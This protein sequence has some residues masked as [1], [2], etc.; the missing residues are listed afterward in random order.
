[1]L[2]TLF[3]SAARGV[4]KRT[5]AAAKPALFSTA[6]IDPSKMDITKAQT[7]KLFPP[8]EELLFGQL[9]TDHM[10]EIDWTSDHGWHAP[11]IR[12]YGPFQMD[13]A[14]SVLHYGLECFEGMKG[15]LDSEGRTRLFRPDMNMARMKVSCER[16]NLPDFDGD[17]FLEC[18]K[19]LVRLDKGCIPEGDGFSLYLRP[20]AISTHPYLGVTGAQSSKLYCILSPVGPYYPEGFKPVTLY[21]DNQN[22]RAWPGGVGFTKCGGNY[23]PTIKVQMDAAKKGYS[24]VLWLFGDDDQLTEVGTMNMFTF[25]VNEDGDKELVTAPL[26]GTILPGVTRDTILNLAR[27]WGEFKVTERSYTMAEMTKAIEEKRLIECFGAGTAAVVSPIR[28]IS[29]HGTEY[30]VPLDPKNPDA[31]AGPLTQ[32]VWDTIVGIQYG[33]DEHEW[34]VVID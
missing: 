22:R 14:A 20:T 8:K 25:W 9:F 7:R 34:S 15:Y 30:E 32:R 6:S 27:G 21:A 12:P 5:G 17:A 24:Q 18:I 31:V 28:L 11:V 26:D 19:E 2:S 33:R 16:M 23:A 29:Y 3:S 13:P 10:L 4:A 1:M